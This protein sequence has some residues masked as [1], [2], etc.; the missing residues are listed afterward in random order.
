MFQFLLRS[1]RIQL[2][3]TPRALALAAIVAVGFSSPLM[4][5]EHG[6]DDPLTREELLAAA[7]AGDPGARDALGA[8]FS[9]ASGDSEA[10]VAL[11]V[12]LIGALEGDPVAIADAATLIA[13]VA[14]D[15]L[16]TQPIVQISVDAK[17]KLPPG[18]LGWDLGSPDS[19]AF[20]GFSKLTQGNKGIVSGATG[21]VQRPGGE[22]LLSDGLI[23]VSRISLD[24]DVPDG[25]YRLIL[26]TDDQ[27][28]QNFRSPL[29]KAI[30]VNGVRTNMPVGSPDG[31]AV[32]GSLGGSGDQ[33]ASLVGTGTGGAT[34]IYVEVVNGKLTIEF[35]AAD[36]FDIL[37]TALV[38]EPANGPSVLFTAEDIF[39]DN[40]E[41]LFAEAVIADAIGEAFETIATAAGG[42]DEREDILDLDDPEAETTDAVRPS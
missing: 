3:K 40:E 11:A 33:D 39:T 18:A 1:A 22:G 34:M 9:E 16:S 38:L 28:T 4:A 26:M 15:A 21:G 29:G 35:E 13:D 20:L 14:T 8:L 31:W 23:N 10:I 24:V 30:T 7:L 32:N 5:A 25:S 37:L 36:N 6:E 27:G 2:L 42:E 41:F 19:P 17:F 12:E